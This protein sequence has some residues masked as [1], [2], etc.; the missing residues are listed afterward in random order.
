MSAPR[1][2]LNSAA[3][4][5]AVRRSPRLRGATGG[6]EGGG[7]GAGEEEDELSL[8]LPF[9]WC[10]ML[11]AELLVARRKEPRRRDMMLMLFVSLPCQCTPCTIKQSRACVR[12][13]RACVYQWD[14]KGGTCVGVPEPC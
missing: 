2:A 8:S 10:S 7:D 6:G 5:A 3:C 9:A 13:Q 12:A 11:P 4:L 1:V 14:A